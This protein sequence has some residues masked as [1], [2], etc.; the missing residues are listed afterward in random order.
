MTDFVDKHG[1]SKKTLARYDAGEKG[2]QCS[3]MAEGIPKYAAAKCE[4]VV[5][6]GANNA[7]I[8]VG[9][10]R[11][12]GRDSGYGG[13]GASHCGMISLVAGRMGQGASDLGPSANQLWAEPDH[14]SDAAFIYIS[15]KTDIDENLKLVDGKVGKIEA[16][17][18]IA[19]KADNVRVISR[20][21]IK[22]VTGTDKKLSTNAASIATYGIDLIAGNND[23]DLQPIVKGENLIECL[24]RFKQELA[25][26]NGIF[27]GFLKYQLEF[28]IGTFYHHHITTMPLAPNTM[29]VMTPGNPLSICGLPVIQNQITRTLRSLA[30]QKYNLIQMQ[31]EFLTPGD[32]E[33]GHTHYINSKYNNVN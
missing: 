33:D 11:P 19:I 13:N 27:V 32:A 30:N 4:T 6:K 28:N 1:W 20:Q 7:W 9:R 29:S 23:D 24:T 22:L 26:L 25:K 8:V 31:T 10:D 2:T 17:S 12:A 5:A 15:Q 18:G 14:R 16:K 21:G 3:S